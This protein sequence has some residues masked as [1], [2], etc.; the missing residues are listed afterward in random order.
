MKGG[1]LSVSSSVRSQIQDHVQP[2]AQGVSS[3]RP[4][5]LHHSVGGLGCAGARMLLRWGV[6]RHVVIISFRLRALGSVIMYMIVSRLP[7]SERERTSRVALLAISA[8]AKHCR[9]PGWTCSA[10]PKQ[11]RTQTVN[12]SFEIPVW[13]GGARPAHTHVHCSFSISDSTKSSMATSSVAMRPTAAPLS[14]T[15]STA[16]RYRLW[17]AIRM[18]PSRCCRSRASMRRFKDSP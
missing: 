3:E 6:G 10:G 15:R 13:R 14:R 8:H 2:H 17:M 4:A 5:R 12:T 7:N 18:A 11:L 1:G 16:R 9:W